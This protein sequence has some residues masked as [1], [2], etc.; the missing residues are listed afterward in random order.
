M[1]TVFT[2]PGKAGDCLLQWPVAY[3]WAKKYGKQFE[4]WLDEKTCRMLK[5]LFEAQSCVSGVVLKDGIKNWNIGG[6]PWDFG[7]NTEDFRDCE[8]YHL[9]M[10]S[11][12]QRQITL[13]TLEWVPF[14]VDKQALCNEPALETTPLNPGNR[15]VLHANFRGQAAGTPGFWRFLYRERGDLESMFDEITFVGTDDE[16]GRALELYPQWSGFSDAGD[17]YKLACFI[18]GS[19]FLIGPGS[20]IAHLG[21]CLKVPTLRVHDPLGEF[22]KVIWSGLG[23]LQ[24]N[25]TERELRTKWLDIK[26][27]VKERVAA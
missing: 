16:V 18:S 6:Q 13:Q 1:K 19:R 24:F 27:S 11:F 20:S 8:I 26:C 22:P 9:G 4:M 12:P 23:P 14:T 3:W 5:P 25:E 10:R 15:L 2:S 17:F 21:N 7:L